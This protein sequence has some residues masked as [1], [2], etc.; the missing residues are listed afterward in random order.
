LTYQFSAF[1]IEMRTAKHIHI[2]Y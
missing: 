1:A 2:Q